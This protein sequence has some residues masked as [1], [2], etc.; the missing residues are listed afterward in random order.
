MSFPKDK[1]PHC[2]AER[3]FGAWVAAHWHLILDTNC[4]NPE[5]GKP[6]SVLRGVA[7]TKKSGKKRN[8]P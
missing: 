7:F 4:E 6:Y 8:R 1:C 3:D 2:G 5:C